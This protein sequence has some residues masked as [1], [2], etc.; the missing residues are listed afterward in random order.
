MAGAPFPIDPVLTGIVVSYRNA[1]MVADAVLPRV[2]PLLPRREF[3]WSKFAFGQ[4]VTIPDTR[5]GRKSTPT[6]VEFEASEEPGVT[7]DYALDDFVPVDDVNNAPAGYN[8]MAVAAQTLADIIALD[9]EKRVADLVFSAATYGA[10]NKETLAGT[11]QW[12]DPD[13]TPIADIQDA[14]D[15]MLQDPNVL[16]LGRATWAALRRHPKIVSAVSVSGTAS[17]VATRQAVADLLEVEEVVVGSAWVN[18]AR[19]GQAP[20]VTR[21]WGKHAALISRNPLAR[22]IGGPATFGWTAE[23]GG[24]VAGQIPDPKRGMR[25]GTTV[26]VGESVREVIAAADL[27]YLFRD[28]VA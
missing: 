26:R 17:G 28:A 2:G 13:S 18:T 14:R 5:V 1:A 9:R 27:G 16:L 19:P 4:Q 6:E 24:R 3:K 12:S 21:L 8:P 25:G 7:I 22:A 20:S 11:S 15:G 23:Y 10:S